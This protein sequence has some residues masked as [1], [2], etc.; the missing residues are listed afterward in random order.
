MPEFCSL[1]KLKEYRENVKI[2]ICF[3]T[4]IPIEN[5]ANT[6][7]EG[8]SSIDDEVEVKAG[9]EEAN[10]AENE[11]EGAAE[12]GIEGSEGSEGKA[13]QDNKPSASIDS[14]LL[15]SEATKRGR[16][17]STMRG[18][19]QKKTRNLFHVI[20]G[21]SADAY[22]NE[23]QVKN[24]RQVK[25]AFR[26]EFLY[27]SGVGILSPTLA[28]MSS[29]LTYFSGQTRCLTLTLDQE[30]FERFFDKIG[31]LEP[32]MALAEQAMME[33]KSQDPTYTNQ[34]LTSRKGFPSRLGESPSQ[35]KK[36]EM[37]FAY[38]NTSSP[39]ENNSKD[40]M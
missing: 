9:E 4:D 39:V 10:K 21:G 7:K 6:E 26:R 11:K 1:W 31:K 37:K 30:D 17:G 8:K 13:R 24:N 22:S 20:I 14:G 40:S 3:P 5:D 29:E 35:S 25:K 19:F 18:S 36:S 32:A 23:R 16:G 38:T 2:S 27:G 34:S 15:N 12:K 33:G 28:R